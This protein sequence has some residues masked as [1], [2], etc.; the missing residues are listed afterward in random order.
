MASEPIDPDLQSS[1][2]LDF[3]PSGRCLFRGPLLSTPAFD[4]ATGAIGPEVASIEVTA[5]SFQEGAITPD[6]RLA[7]TCYEDP[8]SRSVFATYWIDEEGHL[9]PTGHELRGFPSVSNL[10][11]IPHPPLAGDA[12]RDGRVDA[13][14]VVAV[15]RDV[16]GE[17]PLYH[18]ISRENADLDGDADVDTGDLEALIVLLNGEA[19]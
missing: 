19:P 10:A 8:Y 4:M 17:Q 1:H 7:I 13:A 12:N 14:D 2:S 18:W 6:G 9:T 15:V 5:Q 11:V 16:T 3:H